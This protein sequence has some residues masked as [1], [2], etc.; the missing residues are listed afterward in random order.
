MSDYGKSSVGKRPRRKKKK[1]LGRTLLFLLFVSL[2]ASIYGLGQA[3]IG[4]TASAATA[5]DETFTITEVAMI[6]SAA[7]EKEA[8][9]LYN[10][11]KRKVV[12]LTFD[13]GPNKYTPKLLEILNK[14][15]IKAT[16][17]MLGNNMRLNPELVKQIYDEGHYP[18]IHSMNHEYSELYK[19]GSSTNFINQ[20]E[21]AASIVEQYTGFNPTLIRAPYGSAPQIGENFRKDIADAGFKMWDWTLDTNDWRFTNGSIGIVN[22]VKR[23]LSED[24]E[25]ILMHDRKQTV[26]ALQKI[27]DYIRAQ[28]YEFEVYD[29][30][31]HIV[32]NFYNDKRL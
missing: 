26:E 19:S 20:F 18:G 25:I 3:L 12:Y 22:Q 23:N 28:G 13:D 27:I 5:G 9:Q 21:E 30:S 31:M 2:G 17:F 11:V 10:G 8:P 4:V 24:V 16:F 14:N 15:D 32:C 7:E 6:T 29:P 1:W